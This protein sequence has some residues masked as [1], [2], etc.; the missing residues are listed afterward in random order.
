MVHAFWLPN[1]ANPSTSYNVLPTCV[2]D[3]GRDD[4]ATSL[5]G[6]GSLG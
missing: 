4:A 2:A 6:G 3:A 1:D 5:H